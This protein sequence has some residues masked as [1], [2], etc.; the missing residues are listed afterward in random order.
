MEKDQKHYYAIG[1]VARMLN[2]SV[3]TIRYW[4]KMFPLLRPKKNR[5]GDR[6]FTQRDIQLLKIIHHLLRTKGFT[7]EG[8]RRHLHAHQTLLHQLQKMESML[9]QLREMLIALNAHSLAPKAE[10]NDP[11]PKNLDPRQ[12]PDQNHQS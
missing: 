6:M 11:I 2:T 4:E 12:A 1:E 10:P 9:M 3:G 7:I 8:A 5:R